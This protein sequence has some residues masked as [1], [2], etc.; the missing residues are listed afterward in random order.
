[1][2]S[3]I[4]SIFTYKI[5]DVHVPTSSWWWVSTHFGWWVDTKCIG[6]F[7]TKKVITGFVVSNGNKTNLNNLNHIYKLIIFPLLCFIK[8]QYLNITE[9]WNITDYCRILQLKYYRIP[10]NKNNSNNLFNNR[11]DRHNFREKKVL[12]KLG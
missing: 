3:G 11:K 6:K 12:E 1:M 2:K 5:G 8:L 4:P 10:V 9:F 7:L